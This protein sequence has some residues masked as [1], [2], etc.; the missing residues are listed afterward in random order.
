MLRIDPSE[1]SSLKD[2]IKNKVFDPIRN[3]QVED[4]SPKDIDL[5]M[6]YYPEGKS[7]EKTEYSVKALKK[8]LKKLII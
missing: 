2:L 8:Y 4:L 3:E 1:R 7:G 5:K 6:D